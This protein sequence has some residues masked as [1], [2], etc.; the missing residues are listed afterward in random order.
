MLLNALKV[1]Q[2]KNIIHRDLKP[3]NILLHKGLIKIADFGV[4][5]SGYLKK[6]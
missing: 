2:D 3:E 5:C 1:L 6:S 4:S